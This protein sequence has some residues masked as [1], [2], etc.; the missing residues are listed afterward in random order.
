MVDVA[1]CKHRI[2]FGCAHNLLC[3]LTHSIGNHDVGIF[4]AG[5][6]HIFGSVFVRLHHRQEVLLRNVAFAHIV[7]ESVFKVGGF[8]L[9]CHSLHI[10]GVVLAA[11]A[12]SDGAIAAFEFDILLTQILVRDRH[13]H[14]QR[15]ASGNGIGIHIEREGHIHMV[16]VAHAV[17]IGHGAHGA[18]HILAQLLAALG[19]VGLIDFG[20][21]LAQKP[22]V[23]HSLAEPQFLA[24]DIHHLDGFH[25]FPV[26]DLLIGGIG[27]LL[28]NLL[29]AIFGQKGE[30]F[31]NA[32][33]N[34]VER[35]DGHSICFTHF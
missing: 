24:V 16:P 19:V 23:A 35:V 33:H 8:A 11:L 2:F 9:L 3:Q 30:I 14:T 31:A 12:P 20:K 25:L 21:F 18:H 6:F 28:T 22:E 7:T 29:H 13:P 1:G 34:L 10:H 26:V 5:V 4:A 17:G 27:H 32:S 15:F